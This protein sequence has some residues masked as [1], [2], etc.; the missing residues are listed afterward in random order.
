MSYKIKITYFNCDKEYYTKE[1]I[2]ELIR[3]D[4]KIL[5]K[6]KRR[7]NLKLLEEN[8]KKILIKEPIDKNRRKWIRFLTLFRDSEALSSLKS[9]EILNKNEIKTNDPILCIEYK[10]YG[11]VFDSYMIYSYVEGEKVEESDY[12]RVIETLNKIHSLGYCHG[13]A[14]KGNFLKSNEEIIVID[15]NLKNIKY[16]MVC[17]NKDFIKF[18]GVKNIENYFNS[19]CIYLKLANLKFYLKNKIKK[20]KKIYRN[21]V[22]KYY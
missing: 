5:K 18:L 12:K 11:M 21:N 4:G 3:K 6:D 9:M 2:E 14:N 19:R 10:K 13:D 1:K 8:N 17:K 7:S 22:R 15:S 16:G 20:A